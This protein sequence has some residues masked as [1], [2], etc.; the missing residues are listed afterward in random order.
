M[1]SR[2]LE[3]LLCNLR[4]WPLAVNVHWMRSPNLRKSVY[5]SRSYPKTM[6]HRGNP[7]QSDG[8]RSGIGRHTGRRVR[9][10]GKRQQRR[11][12]EVPAARRL[13][14]RR[15]LVGMGSSRLLKKQAGRRRG[16]KR[17]G[18]SSCVILVDTMYN[19]PWANHYTR[20]S[21]L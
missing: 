10:G 5:V 9:R 21:L 1:L 8:C 17:R 4:L 19:P 20:M 2:T 14:K 13:Q 3:C 7:I 16:R 6:T 12:R 18:R 15:V 11:R